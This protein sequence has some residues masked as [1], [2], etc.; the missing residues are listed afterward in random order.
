MRQPQPPLRGIGAST[1]GS[2]SGPSKGPCLIPES[3]PYGLLLANLNNV[4]SWLQPAIN[5]HY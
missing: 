5:Y 4:H 1:V 2:E 3:R